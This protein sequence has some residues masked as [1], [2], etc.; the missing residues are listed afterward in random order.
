[1]GGRGKSAIKGNRQYTIEEHAKRMEIEKI[2]L[3]NKE[4]R[5]NSIP[6][7]GVSDANGRAGGSGIPQLYK[8]CACCEEYSIPVKSKFEVC[9]VCGWIDDPYQNV[10]PN[11]LDGK[12][13]L[14][15]VQAKEGYK[16]H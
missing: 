1:M 7:S 10:H 14:T 2:V 8:K 3:K 11:S 6:A 4:L 5:D 15:L 9:G 13:P 12:N 16:Y